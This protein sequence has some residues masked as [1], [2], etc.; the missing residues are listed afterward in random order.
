MRVV[1]DTN[2]LVAGLRRRGGASHYIIRAVLERQV[3]PLISVPLVLEY[4]EV[5]K[6]PSL[7]PHLTVGDIEIFLDLWCSR[8]VEQEIFFDWR[9]ALR[10]PDDDML[11]ELAVAGRVNVLITSNV[12]DF[13]AASRFGVQVVTPSEFVSWFRAR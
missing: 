9:P 5:L 4:E 1:I 12:R 6:R 2:V 8:C 11:L 7:L 3:V 10:D 13:E